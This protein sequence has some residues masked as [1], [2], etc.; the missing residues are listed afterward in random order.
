MEIKNR[1]V[2]N[3]FYWFGA[4]WLLVLLL[5]LFPFFTN[6]PPLEVGTFS[7]FLLLIAVSFVL[8]RVFDKKILRR[9]NFTLRFFDLTTPTRILFLISLFCIALGFA[10]NKT[11]PLIEVLKG[12]IHNYGDFEIPYLNTFYVSVIVV[13]NLAASINFTYFRKKESILLVLY[14]LFFFFLL[15]SRGM[16]I[17][18][19]MQ[20]AVVI[21]SRI[22]LRKVYVPILLALVLVGNFLFNGLGNIR[23]G[24]SWFDSTIMMDLASFNPSLRNTL[25]GF[26][27][28]IS[29]AETPLGNLLANLQ[30]PDNSWIELVYSILP[31]FIST[32]LFSG[33]SIEFLLPNPVLTVGTMFMSGAKAFGYLGVLIVFAEMCAVFFFGPYLLRNRPRELFLLVPNLVAISILS[34]FDNILLL[35]GFSFSLILICCIAL[36]DKNRLSLSQGGQAYVCLCLDRSL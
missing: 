14:S 35:W 5:F 15:F 36:F 33:V 25:S 13:L 9:L 1:F 18:L 2:L 28:L 17:Y 27:W 20:T 21:L 4:I 30:K 29:Y 26:S 8:G 19:A 10:I 34:I 23:N 3:P 12:S 22:K 31:D 16:M 11:F 24:S 6:Y 32:R 7:F